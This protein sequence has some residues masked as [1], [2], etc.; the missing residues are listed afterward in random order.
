M[1][2][3]RTGFDFEEVID[4]FFGKCLRFNS[5]KNINGYEIPLKSSGKGTLI[6]N[7]L[8]LVVD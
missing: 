2:N 4:P 5:G 8:Q 6:F 1:S 7:A 3:K